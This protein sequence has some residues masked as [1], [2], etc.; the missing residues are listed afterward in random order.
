V[1]LVLVAIA[2]AAVFFVVR[3]QK[4]VAKIVKPAE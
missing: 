3:K 4:K 1:A 2:A